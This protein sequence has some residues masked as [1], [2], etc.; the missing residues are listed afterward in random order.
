MNKYPVTTNRGV[1][2]AE[3]QKSYVVLGMF[4]FVVCLYV[5]RQKQ[6]W[7]QKE[8]VRV[9]KDS[10]GWRRYDEVSKDLIGFVKEVVNDYEAQFD[11]KAEKEAAIK[12][13]IE[14]DGDMR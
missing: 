6:R 7:Y 5:K 13:F 11:E 1:Y 9:H 8:F 4:E 10:C 12:S 2:L 3:V 14:W